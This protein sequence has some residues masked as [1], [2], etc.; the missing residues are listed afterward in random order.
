MLLCVRILTACAKQGQS[1]LLGIRNIGTA[2]W[3]GVRACACVPERG[4][5]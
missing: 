4:L 1:I 5:G 3:V 2:Q